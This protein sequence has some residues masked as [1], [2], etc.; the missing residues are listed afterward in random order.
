MNRRHAIKS[1]IISGVG[2]AFLHSCDFSKGKL[3]IELKHF[4]LDPEGASNLAMLMRNILPVNGIDRLEGPS[5]LIYMLKMLDDC[6]SPEE[7]TQFNESFQF[8]Q[9]HM[10][11]ATGKKISVIPEKQLKEILS[12][13]EEGKNYPQEVLDFYA[14][15]KKYVVQYYTGTKEYMTEYLHYNII[16]EPYQGCIPVK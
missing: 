10:Q 2:I 1:I 8:F 6:G 9:K 3:G 16:P 13:M 15:I 4:R 14:Y 11:E 7:Q 12:Q 5:A